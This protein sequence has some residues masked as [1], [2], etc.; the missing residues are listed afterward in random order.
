MLKVKGL[1]F[2]YDDFSIE[3][4]CFEVKEGEILT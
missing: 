4:V 3:N 2:S 1:S